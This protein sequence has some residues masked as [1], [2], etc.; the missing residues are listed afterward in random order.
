MDN[1]PLDKELDAGRYRVNFNASNLSS[2]VYFYILEA[3]KFRDV[4]KMVL[5]R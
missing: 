3:S 2:G 4:K 5:V 1:H